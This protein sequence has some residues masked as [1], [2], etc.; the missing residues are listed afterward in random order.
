MPDILKLHFQDSMRITQFIDFSAIKSVCDVGSG[1]GFPGIP[2]AILLPEIKITLLEVNNKKVTFLQT[3]ID[4]LELTNCNVNTLDWRTFL[5]QAP[6]AIDLFCA[7]ASLKP[8]ELI[9]IFS[10]SC[11]YKD[12]Q[13]VYWASKN[14]KPEGNQNKFLRALQSYT[15]DDQHRVFA[16]FSGNGL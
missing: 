4:E 10:P 16:I 7:R 2:L 15:V 1:G 11:A 3:V 6:S 12:A 13:L 9:R 5:R 14:W 8:D